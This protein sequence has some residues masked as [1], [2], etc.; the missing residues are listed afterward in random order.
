MIYRICDKAHSCFFSYQSRDERNLLLQSGVRPCFLGHVK[1][2]GNQLDFFTQQ[3]DFN[4]NRCGWHWTNTVCLFVGWGALH[5]WCPDHRKRVLFRLACFT[6]EHV[7]ILIQDAGQRFVFF[8]SDGTY[9]HSTRWVCSHAEYA[10]SCG[11]WICW[12]CSRDA[13]TGDING[14]WRCARARAPKQFGRTLLHTH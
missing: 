9:F 12:V 7:S 4:S 2:K 5:R 3:V 1:Q 8:C 14:S 6:D 10:R 13:S 11:E